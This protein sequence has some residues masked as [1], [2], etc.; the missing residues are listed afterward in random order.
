MSEWEPATEAEAAMRDAL[1]AG[2]QE[3]YFRLLARTELILPVDADTLAGRAPVGWGTW[4]TNSRTHVLAFTSAAALEACLAEHAGTYRRVAFRELATTWPDTEWWLAVN[5]GLPIEGYLPPW[6]V[7][8]ISRGDV[9]LPGRTLGA[10]ARMEQTTATGSRAPGAVPPSQPPTGRGGGLLSAGGPAGQGSGLSRR[11][12][13]LSRHGFQPPG[14][15]PNGAPNTAPSQPAAVPPSA[16]PP[17]AVPS[18][19]APSGGAPANGAATRGG[20]AERTPAT[21]T[22]FGPAP[23]SSAPTTPGPIS[24][25]PVSPVSPPGAAPTGPVQPPM[26]PPTTGPVQPPMA[27]PTTAAPPTDA[28]PNGAPAGPPAHGGTDQPGLPRR[29]VSAFV[30][31]SSYAP[32]ENL[33]DDRTS[34]ADLFA[35]PPRHG[36]SDTPVREPEAPV[37]EPGPSMPDAPPPERSAPPTTEPLDARPLDARALDTRPLDA[38]PQPGLAP[39]QSPSAAPPSVSP[40]P[41]S[42]APPSVSPAPVSPAPPSAAPPSVSP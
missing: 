41:P 37:R 22:P 25:A 4:T 29:R 26:A 14:T 32:S 10:R 1:R 33:A 27:P 21:G 17:S 30:P 19:G 18:N 38:S 36:R 40:A 35:P 9:R 23:I 13:L 8:Q 24:G 28:T 31:M 2:D 20:S 6:F 11:A 34:A 16:A 7:A 39:P 12:E 15:V 42:A 5:P 3:H